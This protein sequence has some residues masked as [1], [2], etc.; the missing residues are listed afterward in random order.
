MKLEQLIQYTMSNLGPRLSESKQ[1]RELSWGLRANPSFHQLGTPIEP[2]S[3]QGTSPLLLDFL[4]KKHFA[5]RHILDE[6]LFSNNER[7]G[8]GYGVPG[9]ISFFCDSG[10]Y[11]LVPIYITAVQVRDS[12]ESNIYKRIIILNSGMIL[13]HMC[14][15]S[16]L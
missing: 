8:L 10:E 5:S 9:S 3:Y 7:D 1:P 16:L 6:G 15:F 2:H 14:V 4:T 13:F 12:S 11:V